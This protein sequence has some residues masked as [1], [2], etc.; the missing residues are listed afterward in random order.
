MQRN[1]DEFALLLEGVNGIEAGMAKSL[2]AAEGIPSLIQGPDFDV[3]ELGRA[4]HDMARGTHLFVPHQA[5]ARAQRVL[6]DAAWSDADPNSD[7][8]G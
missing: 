5:F 2:L 1:Q 3:A 8:R 6:A 4:V 7:E